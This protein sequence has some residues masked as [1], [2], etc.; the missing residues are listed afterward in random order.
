STLSLHDALPISFR[1]GHD[2]GGAAHAF[3][4]AGQHKAGFTRTDGA[5]GGAD[6]IQPGTAETVDCG[7]RH[8]QRKT[9]QQSRHARHVAVVLARLVGAAEKDIVYRLPVRAG[10]A[11]HQSADDDGAQVVR[12]DAGQGAAVSA[13]RRA[14]GVA[15]EGLLGHGRVSSW[16]VLMTKPLSLRWRRTSSPHP[17]TLRTLLR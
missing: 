5:C 2:K 13:E 1:F 12:T 9:R 17:P 6:R 8:F 4:T 14:D 11:L 15:N 7:A 10:V 3:C 16:I